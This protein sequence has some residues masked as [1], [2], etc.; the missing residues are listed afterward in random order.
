M[1]KNLA[2][3][4]LAFLPFI[5]YGKNIT[6]TTP[7]SITDEIEM[8]DGVA[9]KISNSTTINSKTSINLNFQF[10]DILAP[11]EYLV[12]FQPAPNFNNNTLNLVFA[13]NYN[14][15]DDVLEF[16]PSYTSRFFNLLDNKFV[17]SKE[18]IT[19]DEFDIFN[20]YLINNDEIDEKIIDIYKKS[21]GKQG[22]IPVSANDKVDINFISYT[23]A[24]TLMQEFDIFMSLNNFH[25]LKPNINFNE[26]Y[27]YNYIA[28]IPR[29][30]LNSIIGS[31]AK[32]NIED[33]FGGKL[34][35]TNKIIIDN[36]KNINECKGN[37]DDN[38]CKIKPE[39]LKLSILD[40][41]KKDI[42]SVDLKLKEIDESPIKNND[43]DSD[44]DLLK[45][46]GTAYISQYIANRDGFL[47]FDL[48][49][50]INS[51][52]SKN[53]PVI[54]SLSPQ[55]I[56]DYKNKID[57][58][59][60]TGTNLYN[61]IYII[62]LSIGQ[63]SKKY[64]IKYNKSSKANESNKSITYT[65]PIV[66][67]TYNLPLPGKGEATD[68]R[69]LVPVTYSGN[70]NVSYESVEGTISKY[71]AK[72][73]NATIVETLNSNFNNIFPKILNACKLMAE[74]ALF[75]HVILFGIRL[76]SGQSQSL[77]SNFIT[78]LIKILFMYLVFINAESVVKVFTQIS[79]YFINN[80]LSFFQ[81]IG[82]NNS[83]H[84]GVNKPV[85]IGIAENTF[86]FIDEIFDK[87]INIQFLKKILYLLMISIVNPHLGILYF[88]VIPILIRSIWVLFV[89]NLWI[90][91]EVALGYLYIYILTL[92]SPLFV[93]LLFIPITSEMLLSV[94]Y[95][96]IS[97][98]L[99]PSLALIFLF[100]AQTA[101]YAVID[102]LLPTFDSK[103]GLG[104][105]LIDLFNEYMVKTNN[106]SILDTIA[107][108]VLETVKYILNGITAFEW[109][110][111]SAPDS[112][113]IISGTLIIYCYVAAISKV[114]QIIKNSLLR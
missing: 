91:Y 105:I 24:K 99:Y 9:Y 51:G 95:S 106:N 18:I 7:L 111:E 102:K 20:D 53:I 40:I 52:F 109:V 17:N 54:P 44:S 68:I 30:K 77:M 113:M 107:L 92:I 39:K 45:K 74:I 83:E 97:F 81:S 60:L 10:N 57:V 80:L 93:V 11:K 112:S 2:L 32:N 82:N 67:D 22:L 35:I 71:L 65:R 89:Q 31:T 12:I 59:Q 64:F 79:I 103:K 110:V 55:T 94:G 61:G 41:D 70:V 14:K 43:S 27:L 26:Y 47:R 15:N 13:I 98:V 62:R 8:I 58:N 29:S 4:F 25:L 56:L 72:S 63:E 16:I 19:E 101:I 66:S 6:T 5:A 86:V 42:E 3:I 1:I 96:A 38:V 84:I 73:A 36:L 50:I 104:D 21:I 48:P 75:F 28:Q 114:L 78:N 87:F 33:L 37:N 100:F 90:L 88:I 49:D 85:F 34:N 23:Q 108:R 69:V 46:Y 76:A